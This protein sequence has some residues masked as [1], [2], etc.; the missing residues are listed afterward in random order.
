MNL[1][2]VAI[3]AFAGA[4]AGAVVEPHIKQ[5]YNWVRGHLNM[6]A[7]SGAVR[8]ARFAA[9]AKLYSIKDAD[10]FEEAKPDEPSTDV[11]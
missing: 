6:P 10:D 3:A 7:V 11:N 2:R 4:V 9:G 1:Y 8:K 5:A